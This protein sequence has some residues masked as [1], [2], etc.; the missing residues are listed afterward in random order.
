MPEYQPSIE[1]RRQQIISEMMGAGAVGGGGGERMTTMSEPGKPGFSSDADS[2]VAGY[3]TPLKKAMARRKKKTNEVKEAYYGGEE[4]RK[5]DEKKA[6]YEKKLKEMLPKRAFDQLGNEIDPRSGKKLKEE[7]CPK[8]GKDVCNCDDKLKKGIAK[9]LDGAVEMH[10]EQAK[11]LRGLAKELDGAV[12]AHG[13]QAKR[14]RKS[15]KEEVQLD[16]KRDG[17]SAKDKDYSLHDWFKGGGWKQAGGKYDGKPCAKQPGQTTKPYCRD[18]DDRAS[19]S[20]D[21]RNKRA[22][23]KR[24]EDPNPDRSGKAK[25][26]SQ[27]KEGKTFS[28]LMGEVLNEKKD[29]CYHKVKASAKVWPSAY[30][31]G[32]LVQCRKKGSANYGKSKKKD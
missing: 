28:D 18:A 8:T 9:E 11:K 31:S 6:E 7:K 32:R 25:M 27:K 12:T 3:D 10:G 5:K 4:Q 13:S 30:A 14:L 2:P 21:E 1:E 24:K 26:V 29:A 23:K 15:V 20:K 19:M 16:E 22:A 17:K